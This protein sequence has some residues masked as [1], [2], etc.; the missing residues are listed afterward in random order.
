LIK[1]EGEKR[2]EEEEEKEEKGRHL[3]NCCMIT[4]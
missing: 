4:N 3:L 2:G 1:E